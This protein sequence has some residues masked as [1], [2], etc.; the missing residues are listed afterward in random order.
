MQEVLQLCPSSPHTSS[1]FFS[2]TLTMGDFEAAEDHSYQGFVN[3]SLTHVQKPARDHFGNYSTVGIGENQFGETVDIVAKASEGYSLGE[4]E[5]PD[6]PL[7]WG[8]QTSSVLTVN[9]QRARSRGQSCRE[10]W[11]PLYQADMDEYVGSKG[12]SGAQQRLDSFSETFFRRS[13]SHH[14]TEDGDVFFGLKGSGGLGALTEPPHPP[15]SSPLPS[16]SMPLVL[17][18]PPTPHPPPPVSSPPRRGPLLPISQ[19]AVQMTFQSQSQLQTDVPSSSPQLFSALQLSYS[20]SQSPI[21]TS[22]YSQPHWLQQST[23]S[24]DE[25][26]DTTSPLPQDRDSS[27]SLLYPEET[28]FH[29]R[30]PSSIQHRIYG[31]T[32]C[33]VQTPLCSPLAQYPQYCAKLELDPVTSSSH[34]SW[35]QVGSSSTYPIMGFCLSSVSSSLPSDGHQT[36]EESRPSLSSQ[37]QQNK[38][39]CNSNKQNGR[40]PVYT[41]SPFPSILQVGR[42]LGGNDF[43]IIAS[44]YTPQPMLNP[45]RRGT[46]LFCNLVSARAEGHG[47]PW[48][49][50]RYENPQY[51]G[52][53]IGA[54]FQAELPVFLKREELEVRFGPEEAVREQLL[55][56]PLE[57]LDS[58]TTLQEQVE[59]LL[60]LCNSGAVPGGGTNLELALHC[61]YH[62]QGDIMGT[63]EKLLFSNPSPSGD[64]HYS[65]SDVWQLNERRLFF[66]AYTTYGKEFSLIHKMVKTKCVSQC[67]E[68]YYLSKRLPEKQ[69]KQREREIDQSIEGETKVLAENRVVQTAKTSRNQLGVEGLIRPPSLATSFPCKQCGKM[70]YKIKSRNAH[71][72]IHRQQQQ[73][74][75]NDRSIQG[76]MLSPVHQNQ[77]LTQAHQSQLPQTHQDQM[78]SQNLLQNLVPSPSRLA[79]LQS[80]KT[81]G[82]SMSNNGIAGLNSN[83][84]IA[85]KSSPIP[86]YPTWDHFQMTND[87]G[88]LYYDTEGKA[89]VGVAIGGKGQVQW[90]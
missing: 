19:L 60:D 15:S 58:N 66:K 9:G 27:S 69:R 46:G 28:E 38:A 50:E 7:C 1:L 62:C 11:G 31:S 39:H 56:K 48:K 32:D 77:L 29:L 83:P 74:N 12:E 36:G 64:Y 71:M 13:G 18:P 65:G 14:H 81:H 59:R 90:P 85:P 47:D 61:L 82:V 5:E 68:F 43:G 73:E 10:D 26:E 34:T 37:L 57:E 79:F 16:L 89:M 87:P 52:I 86:L 42:E 4:M 70:F 84:N 40:L 30:Q 78:L 33:S 20:N 22:K 44:H 41:G 49:E 6:S 72:K 2:F 8:G 23:D 35:S 51:R 75:W 45:Q 55:W 3:R 80:S 21:F 67:V 54:E 63:V 76:Q 24:R 17:S 88:G 53:N 25:G